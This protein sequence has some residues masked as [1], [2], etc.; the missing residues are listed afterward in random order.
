MCISFT[1]S[2]N[3]TLKDVQYV[4]GNTEF[5]CCL[6]ASVTEK[7]QHKH[8]Y[9]ASTSFFWFIRPSRAEDEEN[10]FSVFARRFLSFNSFAFVS[11]VNIW[12]FYFGLFA[13]VLLFCIFSVVHEHHLLPVSEEIPIVVNEKEPTSIIAYTLRLVVR[14][15]SHFYFIFLN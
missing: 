5:T 13:Y 8:T 7:Y 2:V 4:E 6:L 9:S 15:L 14:Q 3:S 1:I 10:Y 12:S 11:Q